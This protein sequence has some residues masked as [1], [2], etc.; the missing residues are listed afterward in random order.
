MSLENLTGI[1]RDNEEFI[2]VYSGDDPTK[3]VIKSNPWVNT[4][5]IEK[6]N[7][8]AEGINKAILSS[9]GKVI[10]Y[11]SDDDIFIF[12]IIHKANDL[13]LNTAE[14]VFTAGQTNYED[15]DRKPHIHSGFLEDVLQYKNTCGLSICWRRSIIPIVGL[16]DPAFV[17]LDNDFIC[18]ILKNIDHKNIAAIN[19]V[20]FIRTQTSISNASEYQKQMCKERYNL[21][22]REIKFPTEVT[23]MPLELV[24]L[25]S[26]NE[27]CSWLLGDIFER[28]IILYNKTGSA[29]LI[30]VLDIFDEIKIRLPNESV[31]RNIVPKGKHN[32]Y[33]A[34]LTGKGNK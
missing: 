8:E 11:L 21:L 22:F 16:F 27:L 5:I 12:P 3:E 4:W 33:V 23:H 1:K 26:N 18:R 17:Y 2:V 20:G 7:S 19:D 9:S 6:D 34:A 24:G 25:L 14:V 32:E 15:P 31:S 30:K 29:G 28:S 10:R 13:C